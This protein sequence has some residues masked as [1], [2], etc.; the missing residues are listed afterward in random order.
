MDKYAINAT[1]MMK[2]NSSYTSLKH[3]INN[4]GWI[5]NEDEGREW[6]VMQTPI[7][8]ECWTFLIRI[9]LHQLRKQLSRI[10]C[11]QTQEK[12][13]DIAIGINL[14]RSVSQQSSALSI[15]FE[16]GENPRSSG[17]TDI[18]AKKPQPL[19]KHKEGWK[20]GRDKE[21]WLCPPAYNADV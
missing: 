12:F 18:V 1:G 4:T 13:K 11:F 14:L 19:C 3:R 8:R 16:W 10:L 9:F 17:P 2:W 15:L 6:N 7:L 20:E 5:W 21:E